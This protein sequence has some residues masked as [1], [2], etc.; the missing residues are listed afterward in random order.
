MLVSPILTRR[1]PGPRFGGSVEVLICKAAVAYS[2]TVVEEKNTS[3]T[4]MV[5]PENS[6]KV[7]V[8]ARSIRMNKAYITLITL[9]LSSAEV[10][11]KLIWA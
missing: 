8:L 5:L 4:W 11:S 7:L 1:D 3:F 9:G 6:C 2:V 10:S